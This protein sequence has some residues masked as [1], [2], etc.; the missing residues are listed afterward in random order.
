[1]LLSHARPIIAS[2]CCMNML[3]PRGLLTFH[4]RHISLEATRHLLVNCIWCVVEVEGLTVVG[5]LLVQIAQHLV[6]QVLLHQA[7]CLN[8]VTVVPV[9]RIM[10]HIWHL[11][12]SCNYPQQSIPCCLYACQ[13]HEQTLISLYRPLGINNVLLGK[14]QTLQQPGKKVCSPHEVVQVY[15]EVWEPA[16][17]EAHEPGLIAQCTAIVPL[18]KVCCLVA[19]SSH[20]VC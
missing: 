4:A 11:S 10:T 20:N 13:L 2:R 12:C 8:I 17:L 9:V 7:V 19:T 15:V 1:M 6:H 3:Q 5:S 16:L 14:P 18:A